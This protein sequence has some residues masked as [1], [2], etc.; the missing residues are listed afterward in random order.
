MNYAYPITETEARGLAMASV[1]AFVND[2]PTPDDYY[3]YPDIAVNMSGFDP[4]RI[5][6]VSAPLNALTGQLK[7]DSVTGTYPVDK[8]KK[9]FPR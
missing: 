4:T 6:V 5:F 1:K 7:Y 3:T 8:T 2:A 9:M